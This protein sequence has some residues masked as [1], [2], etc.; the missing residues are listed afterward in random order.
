MKLPGILALLA[1][2][3]FVSSA[4][5]Q[6]FIWNLPPGIPP[7]P[8]PADNPMSDVK[9]ELGQR[10]FNDP[11]LSRNFSLSCS[12]CH[13]QYRGYSEVSATHRGVD[14]GPGKRNA[15]G[16]ANVGY[17]PLLTWANPNATSLE[18]QAHDPVFGEHPVEMG[19]AGREG[20]LVQRL[21]ADPCYRKLF[22]EAFAGESTPISVTTAFQAIAA[23]ERTLLSFNSPYD[24]FQRGELAAISDRASRGALLFRQKDCQTCHGGP[25]FTDYAFHDIGLPRSERDA[26]LADKTGQAHDRNLFRTPSL[27]NVGVTGPFMHDGSITNI[28]GAIMAHTKTDGGR[29][30]PSVSEEEAGDIAGFLETL[31][32]DAFISSRSFK[33]A[34]RCKNP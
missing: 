14:D 2:A 22:S 5:A 12:V 24:R 13:M 31:T 17:F 32:D 9:V 18:G 6:D 15:P 11:A 34:D 4:A 16:L 23:F 26:G 10:L 20:E 33:P 7:P 27:R 25:N 21:S 29:A 19:M 8:V 28:T 1:S 3:V 30:A